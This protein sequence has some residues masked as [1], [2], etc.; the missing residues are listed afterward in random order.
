MQIFG[1]LLFDIVG[2]FFW[3]FLGW[4][5]AGYVKRIKKLE[6][7]LLNNFIYLR[8]RIIK[9]EFILKE[10]GIIIEPPKN[11]EVPDPRGYSIKKVK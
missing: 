11:I 1:E 8:G 4:L 10:A 9:L 6:S 7:E 3:A 2:L 5:V